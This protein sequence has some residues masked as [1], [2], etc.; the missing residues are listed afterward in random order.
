MEVQRRTRMTRPHLLAALLDA[1]RGVPHQSVWTMTM[2]VL[3]MA[4][5]AP[6]RTARATRATKESTR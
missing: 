3:G 1:E 6:R 4:F 2:A 5:G